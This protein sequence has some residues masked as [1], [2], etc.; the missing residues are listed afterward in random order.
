[1]PW[2]RACHIPP[3]E[4][5]KG[6]ERAPGGASEQLRQQLQT[7][8][9]SPRCLRELLPQEHNS[10]STGPD[11]RK[12]GDTAQD[13]AFPPGTGWNRESKDSEDYP[14][15]RCPQ[16]VQTS[17]PPPPEHQSHCH[18]EMVVVTTGS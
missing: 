17:H 7:E 16:A 8:R 4:R 3:A 13:P 14:D 15:V 9:A 12:L 2:G 5:G 6:L 1:M 11:T 18:W 10:S